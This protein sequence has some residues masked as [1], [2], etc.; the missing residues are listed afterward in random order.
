MNTLKLSWKNI[1]ARPLSATLNIV[2]FATGI[3][4]ISFLFL[5]KKQFEKQ[6]ESN[7]AGIDLVVGAKGS[8]L[9]LVLSSIYHLD[10]PTGNIFYDD[11]EELSRNPLVKHTI[12]LSLG[13]NYGGYRI[14][15]TN[16]DYADLY[17]GKIKEGRYWLDDMEV[18]I[19]SKVAKETGLT[20]GSEFSGV[21]GFMEEAGHSHDDFV[22]VVTG[23]FEET[24]LVLDQLILTNMES[25]WAVHGYHED[26]PG[27]NEAE[28]IH[29]PDCAHSHGHEQDEDEF[30]A[31]SQD[32]FPEPE[33]TALLVFYRNPMGAISLPRFINKETN[34]QAASPVLEINR[35]Y[36]LMGTS[37]RTLILIAYLIILIATFSI[38]ISLFNSMKERKYE[39]AL[40]RV[41]GGSRF[42]L[43]SLV[44][45][46]GL[47]IA[48]SGFITGF[49]LSR[50]GL[51]LLSIYTGDQ[52]HYSLNILDNLQTDAVLL[53]LTLMI[54]FIA[55]VFP[56]VKAM[57]T[58]ISKTLSK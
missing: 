43:F 29:G 25:I 57:N 41:M 35:L 34:M 52:F 48:F 56:A 47:I 28:H 42:R 7:V 18:T 49:L 22:Y 26:I 23:I 46:E 21:H 33:I 58:D 51:F 24:G 37:V 11:A 54:G 14:V 15:G 13:D 8:P 2:L 12:P 17:K 32:D 44:I 19:G 38:F 40:I 50:A 55:S 36:T 53:I 3:F 4:I 10:Y 16:R 27:L 5:I 6:M 1:K 30:E 45:W 39:L 9:Q 20:V 31:E